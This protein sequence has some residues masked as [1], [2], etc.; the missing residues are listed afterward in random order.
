MKRQGRALSS[1]T[2]EDLE[3]FIAEFST[4]IESNRVSVNLNETLNDMKV[5]VAYIHTH[6]MTGSGQINADNSAH[7]NLQNPPPKKP[8]ASN[9]S[10]PGEPAGAS[11]IPVLSSAS[12]SLSG[13]VSAPFD[14]AVLDPALR[15]NLPNDA[16]RPDLPNE[17]TFS[18]AGVE[19]R[20]LQRNDTSQRC[21]SAGQE[22]EHDVLG[23]TE[24]PVRYGVSAR[25]GSS[26]V[27]GSDR[28]AEV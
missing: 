8:H 19:L 7:M 18:T 13:A 23:A 10:R 28:R 20:P 16:L 11:G 6:A 21:Q 2:H 14:L 9:T 5:W 3:P 27:R 26:Y 22:D 17:Q 1:I 25:A 4:Q 24:S 12:P 15:P